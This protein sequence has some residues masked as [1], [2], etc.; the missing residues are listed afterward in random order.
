MNKQSTAR[1]ARPVFGRSAPAAPPA[2]SASSPSAG[3]A[4]P[5]DL[6]D[7][8][9]DIWRSTSRRSQAAAAMSSTPD[10]HAV[11]PWSLPVAANSRRTCEGARGAA[12][13]SATVNANRQSST[14]ARCNTCNTV[15]RGLTLF[16]L[17]GSSSLRQQRRGAYM[18]VT[19]QLH[20]PGS[21]ISSTRTTNP[22]I[23]FIK[24]KGWAIFGR[25]H[26][27]PAHAHLGFYTHIERMRTAI[28]GAEGC[29]ANAAFCEEFT[30]RF[31]TATGWRTGWVQASVSRLT[32]RTRLMWLPSERCPPAH[33]WHTSSPRFS[34]AQSGFLAP[35]SAH[36]P[37]PPPAASA[38]RTEMPD[39]P[40]SKSAPSS[41][42][43]GWAEAV[44]SS[45]ITPCKAATH[46]AR[47]SS[48]S[49]CVR[50]RIRT[51]F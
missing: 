48:L 7:S 30:R 2:P 3:G 17:Y 6:D 46:P 24:S 32:W 15:R 18:H 4:A 45:A 43:E 44:R 31:S 49:A 19:S 42:S 10:C 12:A 47:S 36:R 34:T 20:V 28:A 29:D 13:M 41:P 25:Q 39:P 38:S 27:N 37:L 35:Q 22:W 1:A 40:P 5:A 26:L 11:L 50:I 51:R 16:S 23:S 14:Y 33:S 9:R 8:E 21:D